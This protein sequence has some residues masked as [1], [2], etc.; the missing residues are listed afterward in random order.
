DDSA[1]GVRAHRVGAGA[2]GD[3][4]AAGEAALLDRVV[5]VP[6]VAD[7]LQ[8]RGP[9]RVAAGPYDDLLG[10]AAQPGE[11]GRAAHD[12]LGVPGGGDV[13]VEAVVV[14]EGRVGAVGRGDDRVGEGRAGRGGGG[15]G[16]DDDHEGD[17]DDSGDGQ[18][19]DPA[20]GAGQGS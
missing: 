15:A 4:G 5:Q 14:D 17:R 9:H 19:E 1:Y 18:D 10:R 3:V 12:D 2:L 8:V 13:V 16:R 11:R 6:A 7:H 20:G